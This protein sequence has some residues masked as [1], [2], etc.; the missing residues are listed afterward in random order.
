MQS[1]HTM[2]ARSLIE[3][4]YF[5]PIAT[6]ISNP[7]SPENPIV[8][9]NAAFCKLT[10]Y[11]EHEIIGRNCNF[12]RGPGTEP[13]L[14][15]RLRDA[16]EAQRPVLVEIMNYRRDGTPFRNAV[17]V[18]PVFDKRGQLEHF[19]GSQMELAEKDDRASLTRHDLAV[20]LVQTLSPRQLEILEKMAAGFR[21]KQIAYQLSLSEK[22]V[23]MHRTLMFKK[24][25]TSNV[26]DAVRIAVE[27][28]F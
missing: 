16:I 14:T 2:R 15:D 6:V 18:A 12:L 5:S 24:L 3:S 11:P 21:T 10:G 26:S 7:R 13:W 17:L 23:Q 4:I 20:S 9:A 8:A 27:A 22:T 28:G 1:E 25:G 19:I